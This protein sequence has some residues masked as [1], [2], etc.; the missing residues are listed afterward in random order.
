MENR[1]KN[2]LII[3]LAALGLV[4]IFLVIIL[5]SISNEPKYS[6]YED[7]ENDTDQ[8]YAA[9]ILYSLLKTHSPGKNFKEIDNHLWEELPEI[10]DSSSNYFFI[11]NGF[12]LDQD[13]ADALVDFVSSG[14]NAFIITNSLPYALITPIGLDDCEYWEGFGYVLKPTIKLSLTLGEIEADSG[15]PYKYVF[16]EKILPYEWK[17]FYSSYQFCEGSAIYYPLG[18]IYSTDYVNFIKIPVGKGQ[19]FIHTTPLAFSNLSLLEEQAFEYA[20]KALGYLPQ[21]DIYWDEFSKIPSYPSLNSEENNQ[22]QSPLSYILGETSFRW[23][24]YIL[25]GLM[26]LFVIF[27][28]KRKQRVIKV[29]EPNVN[30][31]L[32]FVETI[33]TL[34]YQQNDHKKLIEQKMKYFLAFIRSRYQLNTT[35]INEDLVSQIARR[36]EIDKSKV[37]KIINLYMAAES[38]PGVSDELL[39]DLHYSLNYFYKNCK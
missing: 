3:I 26:L 9:S 27:R 22:A 5:F 6:W 25:L 1:N 21:G 11:G 19:I 29:V 10:K 7:Y 32:E 35:N 2:N 36:A 14:N 39:T 18:N 4:V 28:S 24:W 30:T 38:M 13:D 34:Y 12:Y 23:S 37:Q 16:R 20:S 17:Y 33:G 8:P 15:Y 31:S